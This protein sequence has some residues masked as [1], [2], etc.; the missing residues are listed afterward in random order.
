MPDAVVG[1]SSGEIAAAYAA[2]Y[3]SLEFAIAAAYYRGF[4]VKDGAGAGAMAAVG[5]GEDQLSDIL[6]DRVT[7][8]CENSP[9][10]TTIS[11]DR[12]SVEK[13]VASVQASNP[14]VFA[15]MLK[16]EVAYHSCEL[17]TC[18]YLLLSL[19]GSATH[20]NT[21]NMRTSKHI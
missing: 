21:T 20:L 5:L 14:G 6:S 3:I 4:V 8:A 16:V 18:T 19:D 13:A 1:H 15:R 2:G 10:S 17:P 12:E 9:E 11:G 7:L